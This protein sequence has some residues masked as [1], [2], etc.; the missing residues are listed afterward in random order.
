MTEAHAAPVSL[1]PDALRRRC[2]LGAAGFATTDELAPPAAGLAQQRAEDAIRFG[3]GMRAEGYNLYVMGPEG[4]GRRTAVKRLLAERAAGEERP[5]DRCY[6][7]NFAAPHRPRCLSL[8]PGRAVGFRQ[9]MAGLIEDLRAGVPA[10]F[11][12]DQYRAR[13]QEIETELNDRQS[14][15]MSAIGEKAGKQGIAFLRTPSGFGFA[16]RQGDGVMSPQ[17]FNALPEAERKRLEEAIEALQEELGQVIQTLPRW[18]SE[19]QRKLRDLNREV[20]RTAVSGLIGA[21]KAEYGDQAPVLGYLAEVEEDLLDHAELFRQSK[22][23][24]TPTILGIPVAALETGE[25][26]L[27]RYQVNVLVEHA[28]GPGAPVVYEDNPNHGNLMG[29]IEHLA[30]MGALVTDFTLLKAGAVHRANGGYLVLDALKLLQQPFAWDAL[31][32]ALRSHEI[33][34]EPPGQAYSLISTVSLDPEPIPLALKVVLIGERRLYYLLDAWDPEFRELFKVAGDFEDDVPRDARA[35]L[36]LA[37]T[38]AALVRRDKLRPFDRAAV[39]RVI[40][41]AARDAGDGERLSVNA[42]GIADL[43]READYWAGEASRQVAGRED[44]QRAIDARE[45]RADR[46]RERLRGEIVRGTL[47][48]DTAGARVGQV[49]GLS[50]MQLGDFAFGTPARIT[51]RVRLGSG[52]VV[53]IERETEMGGPIHS[54]G[55]LILGG[56]LAGRYLPSRPLAF[57]ASLVFEQSY[58][59]VEGDSASSAEL[60]ALLSALADAPLS[61]SLAVTG[62]VNQHGDV[63]AI[64]G[65]NQK[66]EGF[67]DLCRE[68][69]LTGAQGVLIPAA[70]VKHLMLR[71]DVV[72][73]VAAG[74]FHVYPVAT[75]DQGAALLTGLAAGERGADGRFPPASLNGRVEQRLAEFAERA[76]AGAAAESARRPLRRKPR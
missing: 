56:F 25:G 60:Y 22:E 40:E 35:E 70:N 59:G 53:D 8:P 54:K 33:R 47:M 49:N 7:F 4:I 55:V 63:Q 67:F 74:R 42:R 51:A 3:I 21:L 9:A 10:A 69:G 31:K 41:H 27:K 34:M 73:A 29:R 76:R 6:V 45:R 12:T 68:R 37:A 48:I 65:V 75:I 14:E 72:A 62:S 57:A 2:D 28:D 23:G 64:G 58:A 52:R 36:H 1:P 39:E 16:P 26:A 43:L 46:V 71:E 13:A 5:Q 50:V 18:R 38:V 20:T 61:Q 19:A 24:E 11:E 44:V 30:Q 66:I 17:D 15:A 32:R